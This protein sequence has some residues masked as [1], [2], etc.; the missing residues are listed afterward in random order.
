[1]II[2][3]ILIAIFFVVFI[4][5]VV[6]N[7][8]LPTNNLK[9]RN[10]IELEHM[11]EYFK[12]IVGFSSTIIG[13]ITATAIVF[14]YSSLKDYKEELNTNFK[15]IAENKILELENNYKKI[16]T[17]FDSIEDELTIKTKFMDVKIKNAV[18]NEAIRS[19]VGYEF[20]L[21]FNDTANGKINGL[22]SSYINNITSEYVIINL[23]IDKIRAGNREGI[24]QLL[25]LISTS[26]DKGII[27]EAY[28]TLIEKGIDWKNSV[29]YIEHFQCYNLDTAI[30]KIYN[31][32]NLE[33][34]TI[35]FY[36]V[37]KIKSWNIKNFDFI[38]LEKRL[39]LSKHN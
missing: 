1:M 25:K 27:K 3:I 29:N 16:Q 23:A 5:F 28:Y 14:S 37:N 17:R 38:D 10:N 2:A 35:A 11:T 7:Q 6:R 24:N 36:C 19:K 15:L 9:R 26:K 22:I 31:S 39:K 34:V 20:S 8:V 21:V 12:W 18:S 32:E 33:E 4:L 13:A 30:S